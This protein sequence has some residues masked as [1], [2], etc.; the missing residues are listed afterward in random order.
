MINVTNIKRNTN[1]NQYYCYCEEKN[2]S[3]LKL[4]ADN[5]EYTILPKI[6]ISNNL[7]LEVKKIIEPGIII[8]IEIN[9]NTENQLSNMIDFVISKGYQIVN[10]DKLL[11][12]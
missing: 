3:I 11:E 12:E 2:D 10:L 5:K 9:E 6:V 8:S 4:C 1:Q 7:L